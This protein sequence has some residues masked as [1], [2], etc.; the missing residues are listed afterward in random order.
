VQKESLSNQAMREIIAMIAGGAY[1]VG[2][3]MPAERSLCEQLGISRGTLRK[4][5]EGLEKL[6]VVSI[7]PN[8]GIY[9]NSLSDAKITHK[10]L[11]PAFD[12]VRLEDVVLARKAIEIPACALACERIDDKQIKALEKLARLMQDAVEDDLAGF[13]KHDML[14]HQAIVQ[15]SG[16]MVLVKAF[17][18]IYEYHRFSS[19][20]TSQQEGEEQ[21]AADFHEK[22]LSALKR[23]DS[24]ACQKIMTGHLDYMQRYNKTAPGAY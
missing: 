8:S 23:R 22:I 9:V 2:E 6:G 17:E 15:A 16:N 4:A 21:I 20:F 5:L 18:A 24:V 11:P 7:R 12:N 14:F 19:V 1:R 10:L 3:R 13:L